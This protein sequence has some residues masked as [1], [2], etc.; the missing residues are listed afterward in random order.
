MLVQPYI[1]TA[2]G[3]S[4]NAWSA[5]TRGSAAGVV[6][7]GAVFGLVSIAA[8]LALGVG[9]PAGGAFVALGIFAAPLA[10]QDFWRFAAFALGLPRS[11]AYNDGVWAIVQTLCLSAA[12]MT[13]TLTPAT[14]IG[15]WGLG[16]LA[17]ALFGLVQFR[18][19]PSLGSSERKVLRGSAT[20][21][22]WFGMTNAL[23]EAGSY[24]T[25]LLIAAGAG[26][27]A[28]G[29]LGAVR[30]SL[31]PAR[32]AASSLEA[33]TL[34]LLARLARQNN[35]GAVGR[36]CRSY[37]F[38]AGSLFAL[39]GC[40]LILAG[41]ASLRLLF[42]AR[43][44]QFSSLLLPVVVAAVA[45]GLGSGVRLGF[46]ALSQ[47][48]TLATIQLLS[49]AGK[50]GIVA[51]MLPFGLVVAVW[52]LAAA[53]LLCTIFS[54]VIFQSVTLRAAA[55]RGGS[56]GAAHVLLTPTERELSLSS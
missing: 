4:R 11:A 9:T 33:V 39:I 53:E 22:G 17:G 26:Q 41:P 52:G 32:L 13:G 47:G 35:Q 56:A 27:A 49:S 38:G 6:V 1:V 44:V 24:G 10:L 36:L 37:G 12:V 20:L 31:A 50:L 3:A 16:A 55:E 34:P 2:S 42:G 28:L 8:G 45:S 18:M 51:V 43:F 21:S 14:A 5:A 29:G 7:F 54:V 25:L 15:S 30:N 19:W 48:R 46:R 23:F 40:G